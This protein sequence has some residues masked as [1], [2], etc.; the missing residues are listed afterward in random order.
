MS[1]TGMVMKRPKQSN[2]Y[3]QV[4]INSNIQHSGKFNILTLC[5]ST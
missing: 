1:E 3:K 2:Y 5:Q 4:D